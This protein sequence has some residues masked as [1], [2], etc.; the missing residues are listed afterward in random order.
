[1]KKKIVKRISQIQSEELRLKNEAKVDSF[2]SGPGY[3]K[4][5]YRQKKIYSSDK[6]LDD[7]PHFIGKFRYF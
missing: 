7:S 3:L 2:L 1:M 4:D 6:N 5:L